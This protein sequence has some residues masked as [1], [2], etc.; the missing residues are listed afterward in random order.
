MEFENNEIQR[1]GSVVTNS[2]FSDWATTD[3][4]AEQKTMFYRLSRWESDYCIECSFDGIAY[5]QIRL[6]HMFAGADTVNVGVYACS[7]E[8][9]SFCADFSEIVL[10]ECQWTAHQ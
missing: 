3:I 1:L 2:G 9:S 6:F 7:P 5:Q 8:A 4:P 10:G